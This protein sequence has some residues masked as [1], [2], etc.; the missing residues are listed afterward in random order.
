MTVY[1]IYDE[2]NKLK[3]EYYTKYDRI[4]NYIRSSSLREEHMEDILTDLL[5]MFLDIQSRN[6]NPEGIIG[7]D[8][9]EY[10]RQ[11]VEAS[12]SNLTKGQKIMLKI[13]NLVYLIGLF[14]TISSLPMAIEKGK[15]V[16]CQY[17]FALILLIV[18]LSITSLKMIKKGIE[19]IVS[20]FIILFILI[21]ATFLIPKFGEKYFA[22]TVL[23][24]NLW[25]LILILTIVWCGY[26]Y[27][28]KNI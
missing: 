24:L 8:V 28:R 3:G 10:C 6:E 17:H 18:I 22:A 13:E 23:E 21:P 4:Y 27:I 25:S 5:D 2:A 14:L 11:I 1:E 15:F 20:G 19:P 9:E 7:H 12:N 16:F 26:F